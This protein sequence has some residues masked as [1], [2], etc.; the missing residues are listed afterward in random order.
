MF[1]ELVG[2]WVY[3]VVSEIIRGN[4]VIEKFFILGCL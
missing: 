2:E 3:D 4:E 1:G